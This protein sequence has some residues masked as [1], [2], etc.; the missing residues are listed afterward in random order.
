MTVGTVKTQG[1][2][3]F[4]INPSATSPA[5]VKLACPTGISGL[6]GPADQIDDTCLDAQVRTYTKGLE[7][8]GQVSVPFN[9]IPSNT[10]HQVLF[11]LKKSGVTLDWLIGFADGTAAPTLSA[12]TPK[13]FVPPASPLRTSIKFQ[14]YI[15]DVNIDIA[16]NEIVRGTLTIQRSGDITPYWNGPVPV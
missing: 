9:F 10:S 7:T 16:T 4:F 14:G 5:V 15:A 2:E 11:N 1:S 13:T 3:L 6:G 12:G 8:P